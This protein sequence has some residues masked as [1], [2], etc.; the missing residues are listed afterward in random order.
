VIG[1][2]FDVENDI[3]VFGR[4]DDGHRP[5]GYGRDGKLGERRA[6]I[7]VPFYHLVVYT[8]ASC[9]APGPI[10]D[11]SLPTKVAERPHYKQS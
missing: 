10:D 9:I 3:E 4:A 1:E 2:W 6:D 11:L 8:R 7:Q 5:S